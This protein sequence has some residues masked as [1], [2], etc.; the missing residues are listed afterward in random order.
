MAAKGKPASKTAA[1]PVVENLQ[2]ELKQQGF[3][4]GEIDGVMGQSTRDAVKARDEKSAA[5]TRAKGEAEERELKRIDLQR[6]GRESEAKTA[7][8]T[9]KTRAREERAAQA[10]SPAGVATQIGASTV[11][12]IAGVG[13]GRAIGLGVNKLMDISQESKN[14][15]LAGVAA[16]RTA[17]LTTREGARAA[18]I[19]SGAMPSEN[20][21]LRVGGRMAPHI[22]LGGFMAGKGGYLL[23]QEDPEGP[24]Y[25]EMFNRAAGLG[26]VGAGTGIAER[27][28]TYGVAPGVAPDAQAMS[29]IESNQLRR[30]NAASTPAAPSTP[31]TALPGSRADMMAQAKR[32]NI[33][34][35]SIMSVEQLREAVGEA[36][37]NTPAPR[38]GAATKMLKSL[39]G[40]GAAASIAYAM[41]PGR[42]EAAD[43]SSAGGQAE[44]LTN[45]G[46]AGGAAYGVRKGI[47]ALPAAVG[48]ALRT[49]SEA[50]APVTIDA[51]TDYSPDE[52]ASARNWMARNLPD[53]LQLGAVGEA[54]EMA[55]VPERSPVRNQIAPSEM[56][57]IQQ[58]EAPEDFETQMRTLESLLAEIG[59]AQE[60]GPVANAANSRRAAAMSPPNF[61][62]SNIP[63]NRLLAQ[64]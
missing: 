23:S 35:R 46:I 18:A 31:R 8:E 59:A 39:A 20:A 57:P 25:P 37:R 7:E 6:Q 12:P 29:V 38:G 3:Y 50:M 45:A 58:A 60:P 5:E 36:V 41:T 22:A 19:R 14:K 54:R 10:A 15:A 42:A 26:M 34:G 56:A 47:E 55:Q 62:P 17:G 40:P 1:D 13:A 16:D 53:A 2:R 63:T 44:G 24:F 61:A 28:I 43:G 27:G 30:N 9:R 51:M 64:Y 21:L 4:A 11:A 32:Y 52:L 49:A 48:G 33:K